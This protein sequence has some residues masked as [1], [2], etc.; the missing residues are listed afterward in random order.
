[1]N[2]PQLH[3]TSAA[4]G[5]DG[6]G[7]RF[8]AVS[9]ALPAALL[10]EVEQLVGYE[11]P[12]DAP[13]RP[14]RDEL[15]VFP[16]ALSHNTLSDGSRLLCRT[17]YT[18]TDYS[19]R[20]GNFHAHAVR[21]PEDGALPGG[22][23]PIEAW[24]SPSWTDRTPEER[25]PGPLTNLTPARRVDRA[26]LIRF[27]RA[28]ADRL[29]PFLADVRALLR[30]PDAPQLLVVERDSADTAHWIAVAS[31]VLPR[32]RAD[33][34]T[35]TTYT[36]RPQLARQQI[37]GTL[38]DADFD[39]AGAAADHRYRVHD[40]AGGNSSPA[41][42]EP[43]P[44]AAVA[45]RVWLADRPEL[46]AEAARPGHDAGHD[47]G[48]DTGPEAGRLAVL[49]AREGIALDAAGRTAAA[50]AAH[51]HAG[52]DDWP[53]LLATLAAGG[54]DRTP[55][56]WTALA[57]LAGEFSRLADDT[58][59]A[60]L[61][62]DLHTALDRA[63]A[64][65]D[66]PL[67]PLLALLGL[68]DALRA[69]RDIA[70]GG[71]GP[72]LTARLTAVLLDGTPEDR[73]TVRTALAP[74]GTLTATV[75][76]ALDEHA[77]TGD[78][79]RVAHALAELPDADLTGHPHLRTAREFGVLTADGRLRPD[80]PALL[81]ALMK[82]A[83]AEHRAEPSVLRAAFRLVQGERPLRPV[84]A[85]TLLAQLPVAWHRAAGLDEVFVRAALDSAPDDREAPDLAKALLAR[86]ATDLAPRQRAA[87]LLLELA[88]ELTTGEAQPGFTERALAVR[89]Q[90]TPLESGIEE[91]LGKALADRLLAEHQPPGELRALIHSGDET[92]LRAY[93]ERAR[94]DG[95][96]SALRRSPS[97][98][99]A[100]FVA[101]HT[102]SGA[103]PLWERTRTELLASV[104]KPVV[105]R[106][107]A[108]D[109]DALLESLRRR[110]G[111]WAEAFGDWHRP[112][113]LGRL[114][115]RWRG[116][117]GRTPG[118]AYGPGDIERPGEE[119]G[120]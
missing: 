43:D 18:G 26:G 87:L 120:R 75:L 69:D 61:E 20:Y 57:G 13:G 59:T 55:E 36:R 94:G 46:F 35:F 93:A 114:G 80:R 6:S 109:V 103:D 90:A 113:V 45:A 105:R 32:D 101:W 37:V 53:A 65:P 79:G 83:G 88:G 102:A 42:R 3:Y 4:P 11:P 97:Y 16:V 119:H 52:A 1:M 86:C 39:L 17:V 73:R 107:P 58:A 60:P 100:C 89:P 64:D 30:S 27:C 23:L 25:H 50:R 118:P 117:G 33:R 54:T 76:D 82:A 81:D 19:G 92:L 2:L 106:M 116:R 7:F 66:G 85:G 71:A 99:A 77:A 63:A 34:L 112:G 49:A 28:R 31:A 111:G 15:A 40:C 38:P 10:G 110:G 62:R 84:E 48:H 29:E 56:E 115:G 21:L 67:G 108:E 44:W 98:A 12:R 24:E 9:A 95:V 70:Y 5:P 74:H 72:A 91:R 41:R 68:A 78:P 22:L 47:A 51:E 14:T 8:T 96:G 104:L